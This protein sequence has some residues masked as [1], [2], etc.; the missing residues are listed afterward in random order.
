MRMESGMVSESVL[1]QFKSEIVVLN[2]IQHRHLVSILGYCLDGNVRLLVYEYMPQGTL[3]RHLFQWKE[4]GLNPLEGLKRL[5]IALDVARGVQYLHSL[6]HQSFI[7]RDLKPSNILPT[8]DMGAK[9][10]DLDLFA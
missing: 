2:E 5:T 1:D 3:S 8:D 7:H 10:V 6:A 4:E 9:V